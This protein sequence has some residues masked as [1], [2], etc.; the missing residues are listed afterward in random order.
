MRTVISASRRTDIPAFYMR[1]LEYHMDKGFIDVRNPVIKD[2]TYR[3]DL[4]PESVHS[5]VL[6]SKNFRPFLDST[7]SRK[8]AYRWYFNFSLVDCPDW[9]PYVPPLKERLNQV[10]EIA[11]RWS[12]LYINWRFDPIVMWDQGRKHNLHSFEAICDFMGELGVP[13]CTFSFVT[14]YN[15]VKKRVEQQDRN[16]YD[17]PDEQKK[18]I[19]AW[20]ADLVRQ[21][22]LTFESCCNDQWLEIDGIVRGSCIPG[23]LLS[24]LTYERCS[25]AHDGSQR[26]DCGCTKSLDIGSYAMSCPHGC[27]Y[28]Y[29]KPIHPKRF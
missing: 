25:H 28:C 22:G 24:E 3:V 23:K 7:I 21:R 19:L 14:W 26:Q 29:A 12:P 16:Y 20:M 8:N 9:E 27:A 13:R 5:L 11:S 17:P 18:E 4:R 15:K 1:W 2:R 10:R 6:W